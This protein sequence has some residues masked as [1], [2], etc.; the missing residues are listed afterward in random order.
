[1]AW[2]GIMRGLGDRRRPE[3]VGAV[4]ETRR[5]VEI[6]VED[7]VSVRKRGGLDDSHAQNDQRCQ[8]SGVSLRNACDDGMVVNSFI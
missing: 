5:S 7:Q 3:Q 4:P 8:H 2:S 6:A 1:M